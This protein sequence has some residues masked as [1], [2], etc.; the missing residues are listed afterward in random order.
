MKVSE[1]LEQVSKMYVPGVVAYYG[2]MRPD[3]WEQ[4]LSDFEKIMQSHNQ[5][6]IEAA[7]ERYV[8]RSCELIRQFKEN[9]IVSKRVTPMD[10]FAMGSE[11]RVE[12]WTSRKDRACLC[13]EK[14]NLKIIAMNDGSH[15]VKVVCGKCEWSRSA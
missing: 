14:K 10:G 15:G 1:A 4:V 5:D 6:L 3:P 13:G 9:Q 8:S 7:A 2:K 12:A 11:Q